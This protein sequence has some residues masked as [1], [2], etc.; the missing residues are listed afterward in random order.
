MSSHI[1]TYK[2]MITFKGHRSVKVDG[3]KDKYSILRLIFVNL[4][5]N[6]QAMKKFLSIVLFLCS[7]SVFGALNAY[8]SYA[9]F[10]QPDG[11]A[12]V[13]TYLNVSGSSVV[14]TKND[15]GKFQAKIEIQWIFKK[16]DSIVHFDKYHLLSPERFSPDQGCVDFIDQQRVPL[17]QGDYEVE[18]K[19]LDKNSDHPAFKTTQPIKV[20]YPE[21]RVTLS[22]IELIESYNSSKSNGKFTKSG[23][24]VI[25]LV[26]AF[27]PKEMSSLKFYTEIYRA[28]AVLGEEYLLRYSIANSG[29]NRILNE[30]ASIKKQI[31][32]DVTVLIAEIPI[33]KLF[34]GN[35]YLTVEAFNKRNELMASKQVFFQ[36]SNVPDRPSTDADLAKLDIGSTFV[37]QIPEDS[38]TDYIS[39]LYPISSNLEARSADNII[40]LHD[41][42][43][44]QKYFYT[45]WANQ[46]P[47]D[48]ETAWKAYKLE[49]ERVNNSFGSRNKKGYETDRGRVY[50]QYGPPNSVVSDDMDPTARPYS[51]WHY[52][53][54]GNQTNRKFVFYSL[55]NSS[56][57]YLLLHSDA[58]GELQDPGW[59]LK[60]H[61]RTQQFG[62]DM[63]QEE[64][65][66]IYGSKTKENFKNPK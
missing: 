19:I 29:N 49:V 5:S 1:R 48:P 2:S 8:F 14:L 12:Y 13:E 39:C 28:K 36:R 7:Q 21:D 40:K 4:L 52:Y 24:E 41:V 30:F 65:I 63:D 23:F 33:E 31:S 25:P 9:T 27:Y 15:S 43:N 35:Y 58:Q 26:T 61:N 51:I 60:L 44:M 45:F 56:N 3:F 64:S 54:L 59:E 38:L 34:S 55:G 53:Q 47:A 42:E 20:Y 46:N 32:E 10:D 62:S 57:D 22:D 18:L 16:G 17:I 50:L 11:S 66:D 37:A 6:W